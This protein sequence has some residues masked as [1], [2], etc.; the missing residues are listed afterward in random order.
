MKRHLSV[1]ISIQKKIAK[2]FKILLCVKSCMFLF[3]VHMYTDVLSINLASRLERE[4]RAC[5][6]RVLLTRLLK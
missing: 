4:H 2:P 1:Q 3:T 5:R 6:N